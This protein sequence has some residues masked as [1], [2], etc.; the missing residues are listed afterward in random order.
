M[1]NA[2]PNMIDNKATSEPKAS[3]DIPDTPWPMVQPNDSTPPNPISTPAIRG[4]RI[5]ARLAQASTLKFP[6]KTA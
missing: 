4:L 2:D 5:S 1:V 6:E 3:V